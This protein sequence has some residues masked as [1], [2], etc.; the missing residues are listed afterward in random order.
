MKRKKL[1]NKTLRYYLFSGGLMALVA[2]PLYYLGYNIYY[3]QETDEFLLEQS[4]NIYLKSLETLTENK[5]HVWNKYNHEA[6]ILPDN[7]Q[8]EEN[9]FV[10]RKFYD[11]HEDEEVECRVLYSKIKIEDGN[12][13]LMN[14]LS[15]LEAKKII[16]SGTALHLAFFFLLLL[17]FTFPSRLVYKVYKKLWKPFYQTLSDV[18]R[19]NIRSSEIPVFHPT[20]IQEFEQ[21]NRAVENLISNS[22]QAYKIQKEFTENASHEMQ[23]PLAVFRS[24]LDILLQQKDLTGEQSQIIQSLYEVVSRLV[25]M[26]KNLLLLAK[27]DNMQFPDT[28]SLNVAEIVNESLSFLSE[29]A[30]ANHIEIQ[31]DINENSIVQA[32]KTLL[33]SLVN[34]LLVNAV[35]HNILCGKIHIS[36]WKSKLSISNTGNVA[37]L[38]E[39]M[40]FRRFSRMNEKVKGSGLGLAIARQICLLYG[41]EI[42]YEYENGR[43]RFEVNF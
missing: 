7:G 32:N 5:I 2:I 15:M 23:T 41:W 18:E 40:L 31:T 27:I 34:N 37:G 13:L 39:N 4:N 24:K 17:G 33:E 22:L 12:Y 1:L 35:K 26:N 28:Q 21:L 20:D 29:Q 11:S 16:R 25:H 38:N 42:G 14:R 36:L 19:F 10:T 30:E 3:I 9:V 6:E 43:H 8:K